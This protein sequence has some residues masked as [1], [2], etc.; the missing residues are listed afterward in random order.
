MCMQPFSFETRFQLAFI[1]GYTK[2]IN[3]Y[4]LTLMRSNSLCLIDFIMNLFCLKLL[5]E[6]NIVFSISNY[7]SIQNSIYLLIS[8]YFDFPPPYSSYFSVFEPFV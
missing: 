6:V 5:M 7:L 4:N 3:L 2:K 8:E 1:S